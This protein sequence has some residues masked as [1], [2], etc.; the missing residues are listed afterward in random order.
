MNI[1]RLTL[2]CSIQFS[3]L[4]D[5]VVGEG[6]GAGGDMRDDSAESLFQSFFFFFSWREARCSVCVSA[7]VQVCVSHYARTHLSSSLFQREAIVN[8]V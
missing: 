5:W 6:G 3:L 1:Q 8:Q 4:T 7:C 2:F